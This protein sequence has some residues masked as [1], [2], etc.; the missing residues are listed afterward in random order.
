M[1]KETEMRSS[2]QEK[3]KSVNCYLQPMQMNIALCSLYKN[4]LNLLLFVVLTPAEH[5][6]W[7]QSEKSK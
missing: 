5:I 2:E 1:L 6:N 4:L 7:T 3:N